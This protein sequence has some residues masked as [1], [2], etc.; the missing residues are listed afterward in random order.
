MTAQALEAPPLA[1]ATCW[2]RIGVR[3]DKSCPE[4]STYAHCRNCPTF[5]K[6]AAD[7]FDGPADP[8]WSREVGA[9]IAEARDASRH[10]DR[11]AIRFRIGT[12]WFA[13]ATSAFDEVVSPRTIH[14]LPHKRTSVVLGL[15]NVRGDLIICLSLAHLMG[16]GADEAPTRSARLLVLRGPSGRCAVPVDEVQ[17]TYR[18]HDGQL[19]PPPDTV[20]RAGNAFTR[21]LLPDEG[22]ML[23]RLDETSLLDALD[24]SLS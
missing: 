2:N 8:A 10:K 23:S 20:A 11:S 5:S 21:G 1:A 18:Y 9:G 13:L 15:V 19:L 6:A 7:L 16:I 24:R 22:R 3:G 4:L 14:S 12:E 17:H